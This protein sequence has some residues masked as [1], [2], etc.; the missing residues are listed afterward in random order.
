MLGGVNDHA[1]HAKSFGPAAEIYE[2]GRPPYPEDALDWLLPEGRPRVRDLGAGTGKLTRQVHGRGLEV[3]A[4]DPSDGMLAE[5]GRVLPGLPA[6][7]GSAEAIPLPDHAVDA[8]LVAQA[9]HWVDVGRAVPEVARVLAPG[10]RLGLIWNLRDEREDWVRE[11]G[12]IMNSPETNRRTT[13]GA[14]FGPVE[15]REFPWTHRI[16]R[17]QIFDLVASRS[18]AILLPPADRAVL[19]DRVRDLLESHPDLTGRDQLDL[20]YITECA[21]ADLTGTDDY[22]PGHDGT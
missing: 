9:W 21:R 3:T 7:V 2:R 13:I 5:L 14:P 10:G 15:V 17:E 12:R 20:P 16:G 8:V 4:V 6:L 11:L 1:A 22:A 18:A 19:L